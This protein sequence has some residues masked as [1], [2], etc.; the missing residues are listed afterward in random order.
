MAIGSRATGLTGFRNS[1][2]QTVYV[3][4]VGMSTTPLGPQNRSGA[5]GKVLRKDSGGT[6]IQLGNDTVNIKRSAQMVF[7]QRVP[8]GSVLK[9]FSYNSSAEAM[10]GE[11]LIVE[12]LT[13]PK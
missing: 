11:R 6:R 4:S 2:G 5:G 9:T 8:G 10:R 1:T 12:Q 7:I 13:A 3:Q